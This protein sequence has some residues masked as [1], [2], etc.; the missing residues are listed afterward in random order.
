MRLSV[1]WKIRIDREIYIILYVAV[2][3]WGNILSKSSWLFSIITNRWLYWDSCDLIVKGCVTKFT[4]R[5][6]KPGHKGEDCPITTCSKNKRFSRLFANGP[7]IFIQVQTV[8]KKRTW[9]LFAFSKLYVPS[10]TVCFPVLRV[11]TKIML[12][13]MLLCFHIRD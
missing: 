1:I 4:V 13:G 5:T 12:W 9:E 10:F 6:I 11:R 7:I 2:F 8:H 3:Y